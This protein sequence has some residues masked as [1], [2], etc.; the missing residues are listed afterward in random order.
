MKIKFSAYTFFLVFLFPL[1]TLAQAIGN[2]SNNRILDNPLKVDTIAALLA[3][4]L[5]IVVQVG[6]VVIVF[7]VI[8]AGFKYVTARGNT[9]EIA[10]AHQALLNTLIGAAIVLGSYAIAKAL[11][12]TV[13]QL[14]A[15]A[16]IHQLADIKD[17][18]A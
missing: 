11:E 1:F 3:A 9:S 6:L 12:N 7:F 13:S 16:P 17:F 8:F 5:D 15:E 14:K 2:P 18:K 4:V 10:K